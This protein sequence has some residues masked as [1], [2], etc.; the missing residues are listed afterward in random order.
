MSEG[1]ERLYMGGYLTRCPVCG[2]EYVRGGQIGLTKCVVGD[3]HTCEENP[4]QSP[5]SPTFRPDARGH[6]QE[7]HEDKTSCALHLDRARPSARRKAS[8]R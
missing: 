3:V 6:A 1:Y 4:P 8:A 7:N 5:K 2:V